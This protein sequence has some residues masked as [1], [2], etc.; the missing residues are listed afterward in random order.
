MPLHEGSAYQGVHE[1]NLAWLVIVL[2]SGNDIPA[3][4]F[5]RS[6]GGQLHGGQVRTKITGQGVDKE[7]SAVGSLDRHIGK[8]TRS[9]V[10][11]LVGRGGGVGIERLDGTAARHWGRSGEGGEQREKYVLRQHG[12]VRK[13]RQT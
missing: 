9:S 12:G 1:E 8:G 2:S 3:L 4:A 11:P 7:A 5:S 10:I 13:K 6:A